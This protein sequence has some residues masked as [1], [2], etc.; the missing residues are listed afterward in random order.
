MY[1]ISFVK[2]TI[3]DKR[4]PGKKKLREKNPIKK[5]FPS[6]IFFADVEYYLEEV[7]GYTQSKV[8]TPLLVDQRNYT[9]S[10]NKRSSNGT[11]IFWGCTH[12]SS[13]YRLSKCKA[14]ATTKNNKITVLSGQ[15]THEPDHHKL[16]EHLRWLDIIVN[17]NIWW[18]LKN[19]PIFLVINWFHEFFF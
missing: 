6:S 15:H 18:F 4:E 12:R 10:L 2:W 1:S 5:L 9:Y 16:P 17:K 14:R 11:T 3:A 8:G 7:K 19:V 13:N